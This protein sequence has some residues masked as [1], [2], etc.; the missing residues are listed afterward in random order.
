MSAL[1]QYSARGADLHLADRFIDTPQ[2]A[3]EDNMWHLEAAFVWGPF[4]MQGE[5]AELEADGARFTRSANLTDP[6]TP[7]NP[8]YTGWYVDASWY[9]TGE[10][11]NY[12]GRRRDIRT[13]QGQE[14]GVGRGSGGY[15]G[16]RGWGA[17]QIAGRY[18]VLDLS[19]KAED[20]QSS[21]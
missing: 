18:D 8:T 2:F 19:D 20:M 21:L 13:H 9:L 4:S 3:E 16:V 1:F 7:V 11:R 10:T 17:W 12:E 5:Y 14:P 6:V 15:N